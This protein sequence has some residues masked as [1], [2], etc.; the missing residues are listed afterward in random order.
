MES[1]LEYNFLKKGMQP[2]SGEKLY[3]FEKAPSMPR[4]YSYS[5]NNTSFNSLAVKGNTK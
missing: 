1:L 4:L 5:V 2:R 3:L